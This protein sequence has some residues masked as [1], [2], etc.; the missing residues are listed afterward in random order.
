MAHFDEEFDDTETSAPIP[1]AEPEVADE[2]NYFYD[3]D[4]LSI[5]TGGGLDKATP[6]D[7]ETLRLAIVPGIIPQRRRVH[8]VSAGK[9]TRGFYLC[10]TKFNRKG[11]VE[12][13]P[14]ICCRKLNAVDES[15][16]KMSFA[17]LVVVYHGTQK[18]GNYL[19]G[20]PVSGE[21]QW[22]KL[23]NSA[24]KS[25]HKLRFEGETLE[26]FD[27]GISPKEGGAIGYDY[28]R[29]GPARWLQNTELKASIEAD[30]EGYKDGVFLSRRLGKRVT[31]AEF[32]VVL[33]AGG[34]Q[35]VAAE[36]EED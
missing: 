30:C 26:S 17:A 13:E 9:K 23:S 15:S 35:V 29:F 10:L 27:F 22:L 20:A 25:L 28:N 19:K 18:N 12:G 36:D 21:L 14:G 7:G 34:T 33:A 6:A 4:S 2:T 5:R 32:K 11:A 31:S 16:V 1:G 3:P 24:V 8:F